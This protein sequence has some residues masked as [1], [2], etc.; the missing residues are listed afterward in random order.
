MWN[1]FVSHSTKSAAGGIAEQLLTRIEAEFKESSYKLFIDRESIK[2]GDLWKQWIDDATDVA[3][4]AIVL[5]DAKAKE[6]EW[7]RYEADVLAHRQRVAGLTIIPVLIETRQ[8]ELGK[9]EQPPGFRTL[10][11]SQPISFVNEDDV[12][13]KLRERLPDLPGHMCVDELKLIRQMAECLPKN[14]Q[15]AKEIIRALAGGGYKHD[16]L[17]FN[18]LEL[19]VHRLREE[20]MS[21]QMVRVLKDNRTYFL[22]SGESQRSTLARRLETSWINAEEA[23][24]QLLKASAKRCT[25][26]VG[27]CSDDKDK[28]DSA[29]HYLR[30]AT[31]WASNYAIKDAG[32]V[33]EDPEEGHQWEVEQIFDRFLWNEGEFDPQD[34]RYLVIRA[35]GTEA[36]RLRFARTVHDMHEDVVV[37]LAINANTDPDREL[38]ESQLKGGHYVRLLPEIDPGTEQR[39]TAVSREMYEC[40]DVRRVS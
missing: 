19:L 24:K 5:L 35:G 38:F 25:I 30:Q 31:L 11:D 3:H 14:P 12:I 21:W 22:E 4:A 10:A 1:V 17:P 40:F 26:V 15:R 29:V 18:V 39:A 9:E 32:P 7:V 23:R 37:V 2:S 6:S 34:K 36:T 20:Q 8:S 28:V 27:P 13:L 16:P 33:P